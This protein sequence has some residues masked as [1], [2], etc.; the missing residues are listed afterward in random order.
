MRL[1]VEKILADFPD[2]VRAA[3]AAGVG[4]H[5]TRHAVAKWRN[6]RRIGISARGLAALA[7]I[8]RHEGRDFTL[9]RYLDDT[10]PA[11]AGTVRDD[12]QMDLEDAIRN[13]G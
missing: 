12:Q 2:V 3:E 7:V 13:T 4:R 10:D 8:A 6:H 11:T 5:V 1:N 9:N